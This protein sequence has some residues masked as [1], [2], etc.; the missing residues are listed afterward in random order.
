MA[1]TVRLGRTGVIELELE[2]SSR[3]HRDESLVWARGRLLVAGKTVVA[4]EEDALL[5][6]TWLDLLEWLAVHWSSL[7][8]EQSYPFNIA[9]LDMHT[10]MRDLAMRWEDLP[11]ELV[12]REEEEAIRFLLRHDLCS[13]FKGV[14]F[15]AVYVLRLGRTMQVCFAE[16]GCTEVLNFL[17]AK[18]ALADIADGLALLAKDY[19]HKDGRAERALE[20]W[21]IAKEPKEINII[22][23]S[24]GLDTDSLRA[25]G[26]D[27]AAFWGMT[28]SNI[29]D[30]TELMAAA[31][32]TS[33]FLSLDQQAAVLGL[34]RSL[35]FSQTAEL[36]ELAE[37]LR[38][39]FVA[40]GQL[41]D[42]GYWVAAWLRRRL[43]VSDG[44]RVQPRELLES[45]QV[46]VQH[47]DLA[48]SALD[49]LACWG[50]SHGPAILL[51]QNASN[52]AAH[53]FGENTTLAHEICHLLL[54]RQ[55][56]L[57]VAEVL[58]GNSPEFLEKRA[59]AFAAEL[60]LPRQVASEAVQQAESLAVA[61]GQLS[62]TYSVSLKLVSFQIKNSSIYASLTQQERSYLASQVYQSKY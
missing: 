60:L 25:M 8:F 46:F 11:E 14:F 31:R 47:F 56:T 2:L 29:F 55:A 62:T 17:Q 32:M 18:A 43:G 59:R 38:G 53:E 24:T 48:D 28:A 5:E 4:A 12:E 58:N 57:P 23:L 50:P 6:W 21:D 42:Q 22:S 13:A 3:K 61:V 49:A 19:A 45:W 33:G 34:V 16:T 7:L 39:E 20:Q 10:L 26:A 30:D 36:D 54:D 35:P 27:N 37:E 52:T 1:E 40:E 9:T 41:Y 51:N 15:P 44:E